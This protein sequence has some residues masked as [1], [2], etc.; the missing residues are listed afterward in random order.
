MELLKL[1]EIIGHEIAEVRFRFTPD[2]DDDDDD[3]L[4]TA[5]DDGSSISESEKNIIIGQKNSRLFFPLL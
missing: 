5:F 1:S 2:N 4:Q 3:Y